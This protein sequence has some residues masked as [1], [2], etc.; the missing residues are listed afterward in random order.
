MFKIEPKRNIEDVYINTYQPNI[1][2][3]F[4]CNSNVMMGITGRLVFYL[5]GYATKNTQEEESHMYQKMAE[6]IY[7]SLQKTIF[8]N[9]PTDSD[10]E[11]DFKKGL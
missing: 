4:G 10:M 6:A 5:T 3:S 1:S 8:D 2:D 7:K 9:E 11:M